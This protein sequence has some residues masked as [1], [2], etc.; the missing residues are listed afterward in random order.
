MALEAKLNKIDEVIEGK[1][2]RIN[3]V[4]EDENLADLMD[5]KKLKEMQ[6]EVKILEKRKSKMEKMYEK[7]CGKKYQKEE[8]VDEEIVNGVE[9]EEVELE[10]E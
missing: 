6:K 1:V 7:M 3:M 8:I 5:K 2:S 9:V 4:S 10:N